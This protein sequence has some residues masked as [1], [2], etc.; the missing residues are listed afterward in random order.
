[1]IIDFHTHCFADDI[2]ERAMGSLTKISGYVPFS[3]GSVEGL[4]QSMDISKVDMSIVQP[5]ATKKSQTK[6]INDWAMSIRSDRVDTFGTIHH[7]Y[8]NWEQEIDRLYQNGVKGIKF[9]P[10]YQGFFVDDKKMY[11][12]YEKVASLKMVALFHCGIDVAFPDVVRCTPNRLKKVLLD[13]KGLKVVGAHMGGHKMFDE[14]YD[15]LCGMACYIAHY[16]LGDEGILRIIKKHGVDKVLFASDS[17]W[18]N[19]GEMVEII[20][21]LKLTSNEKDMIFERNAKHILK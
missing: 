15:V 6:I 21:R 17:P 2:V 18:G 20:D 3:D 12:I 16:I 10:D 8:E 1:M 7:E 14:V 13:I 19:V 11:P 4:I 9:H 5:I